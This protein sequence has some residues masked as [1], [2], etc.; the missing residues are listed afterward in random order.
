MLY[1]KLVNEAI[2][3]AFEAHSGQVDKCGIPYV[4]HLIVVANEQ[5]T[6]LGTVVALL[7]DVL[8]DTDVTYD[9]LVERFGQEVADCVNDLTHIKGET[10]NKYI[11]RI[12]S[13]PRAATVIYVKEADLKHNMQWTRYCGVK[14]LDDKIVAQNR[15][16]EKAYYRLMGV[17]D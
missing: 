12:K 17:K 9:M 13:S 5:K 2:K 1:T 7:H 6:E 14:E 10:Y 16:Y 8:E 4:V 15:K 3:F 11:D